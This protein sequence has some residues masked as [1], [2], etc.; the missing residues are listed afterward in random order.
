MNQ[1]QV[2]QG[3]YAG[4]QRSKFQPRFVGPR[5][6]L[7][8]YELPANTNGSW[9]EFLCWQ[10][11]YALEQYLANPDNLLPSLRQSHYLFVAS[12]SNDT[13][14]IIPTPEP[15]LY[16]HFTVAQVAVMIATRDIANDPFEDEDWHKLL[17]GT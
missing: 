12:H 4:P 10:G 14:R 7:R 5:Y 17:S 6:S 9:S 2:N 3:G 8:C 16:G 1:F 15:I 13:V 11:K